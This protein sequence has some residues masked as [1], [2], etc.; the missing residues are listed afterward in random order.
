M[1][2]HELAKKTGISNKE[3]LKETGLGS[4]MSK[5]PEEVVAQYMGE[6]KKIQTEPQS[7][8][9]VDSGEAVSDPVC[10]LTEDSTNETEPK[11]IEDNVYCDPNSTIVGVTDVINNDNSDRP[12]IKRP[13]KEDCPYTLAE[14]ELMC[15]CLGSKSA[16]WKYRNLLNG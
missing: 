16:A 10:E 9:T 4:H 6:E 12:S 5:V 2:I 1:K 3:L 15:R 8:E 14:I 13:V 7:T 11:W